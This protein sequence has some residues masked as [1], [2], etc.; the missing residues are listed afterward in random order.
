LNTPLTRIFML[1]I[2]TA[3]SGGDNA[4]REPSS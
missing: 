4:H 2:K 3:A 1:E